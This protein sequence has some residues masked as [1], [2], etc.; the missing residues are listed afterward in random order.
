MLGLSDFPLNT[1]TRSTGRGQVERDKGSAHRRG[2]SAASRGGRGV[3][4]EGGVGKKRAKPRGKWSLASTVHKQAADAVARLLAASAARQGGVS[5]KS[6]TLAP[7]VVAKKATFAVTNETL[8]CA[9]AA[10]IKGGVM[11]AR[12]PCCLA[13][14]RPFFSPPLHLPLSLLPPSFLNVFTLL[15]RLTT[16]YGFWFLHPLR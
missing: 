8:R 6:L 16:S 11:P 3:G 15:A 12:F 5:I 14:P 7:K 4:G 2:A 10:G 13:A 9:C 1:M